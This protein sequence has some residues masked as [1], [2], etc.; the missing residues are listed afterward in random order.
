[1]QH[2]RKTFDNLTHTHTHTHTHTY[3][4]HKQKMQ[5]QQQVITH[6]R[7]FI[8]NA[9]PGQL[10][11]VLRSLYM[12]CARSPIVDTAHDEN[13]DGTYEEKMNAIALKSATFLSAAPHLVFD[14]LCRMAAPVSI[15]AEH[16][17]EMMGAVLASCNGALATSTAA[18]V[19]AASPTQPTRERRS[20][21]AGGAG[22]A[23]GEASAATSK[24]GGN[25]GSRRRG[26]DGAIDEA[27]YDVFTA[28]AS[29]DDAARNAAVNA[30]FN[31]LPEPFQ[32]ALDAEGVEPHLR[33]VAGSSIVVCWRARAFV[34]VD[35]LAFSALAAVPITPKSIH[36]LLAAAAAATTG[37][38]SR[39]VATPL[40]VAL[41]AAAAGGDETLAADLSDEGSAVYQGLIAGTYTPSQIGA[42][43]A[44]ASSPAAG[45]S[46]GA[47]ASAAALA[48]ALSLPLADHGT[49][50]FV[51]NVTALACDAVPFVDIAGDGGASCGVA[52]RA[53]AQ[54]IHPGAAWAGRWV[55]CAD[56][57]CTADSAHLAAGAVHVQYHTDADAA[58]A[59]RASPVFFSG[60]TERPAPVAIT[61]PA[62]DDVATAVVAATS[63]DRKVA[64]A[65]LR[66]MERAEDAATAAIE[67]ACGAQRGE[68]AMK[69]LR[70]R[71][72]ITQALFDFSQAPRLGDMMSMIAARVVTADE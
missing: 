52:V 44:T 50:R 35:P 38:L 11:A 64:R 25:K 32:K 57:A 36:A 63:A 56:I 7:R 69:P 66:E 14:A 1:M 51:E 55:T 58:V 9:A 22:A 21:A 4:K 70:R 59:M 40:L 17:D 68:E 12:L 8:D 24:K 61:P 47:F 2:R 65:L 20:E 48:D 30:F 27:H 43:L 31:A 13:D 16:N 67:A 26:H 42:I 5:Q 39:L 18:R 28:D 62:V 37:G 41:A 19:F 46:D 15:P 34:L 53:F 23:G 60:S 72:P 45:D 71:L 6:L 49:R 10:A 3:K 29:E 54:R 33:A